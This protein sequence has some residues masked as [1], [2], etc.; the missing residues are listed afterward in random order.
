VTAGGRAGL[1]GVERRALAG[2]WLIGM[3]IV[4]FVIVVNV[5]TRAVGDDEPLMKAIVEEASSA[6]SMAL[7]LLAPGAAALW[8]RRTKPAAWLIVLACLAGYAV[9]MPVHVGGFVAIRT[10][11][12]PTIIDR[13]YSFAP[14]LR[15]TVYEGAKDAFSYAASL[16][17][18][19]L[20]LRWLQ[21]ASPPAAPV[22]ATFDIRDGARLVRTPVADIVAVRSAANYAEFILSDGRRPLMRTSLGALAG[23]L[24][25]HGFVRTHRSWLVNAARVTGLRP[26][27]S[28][29]YAV[30][31]G[32]LE[33]P[34]SR[35]FRGALD[36][37]RP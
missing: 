15:Q 20:L 8:I 13:T 11:V 24:E 2:G 31:L 14:F 27:G 3:A 9:Y 22:V 26:E 32:D 1:S 33:V 36:V 4:G 29:D 19:W 16:L 35:R 30:E 10:L 17:A 25:A 37:L 34:L 6:M 12:E 7:A 23:R 28:G 18:F 21:M 5:I